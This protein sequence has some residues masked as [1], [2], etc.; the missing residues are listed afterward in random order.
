MAA[1]RR[2]EALCTILTDRHHAAFPVEAGARRKW[3][4]RSAVAV[5]V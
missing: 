4:A 3:A 2:A 1:C 5:D